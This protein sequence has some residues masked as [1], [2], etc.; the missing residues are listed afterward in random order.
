MRVMEKIRRAVPSAFAEIFGSDRPEFNWQRR[1]G[2]IAVTVPEL[3]A[4][5]LGRPKSAWLRKNPLIAGG[6]YFYRKDFWSYGGYQVN[7]LMSATQQL[8]AYATAGTF[9]IP[10]AT[11]INATA[12]IWHTN[13][14]TAGGQFQSPEV[15]NV[16]TVSFMTNP[17]MYIADQL[18]VLTNSYLDM[19]IA[20]Q[21]YA[22]SLAMRMPA[23]GGVFTASSA[24]SGNGNPQ[25]ANNYKTATMP[26]T[27]GNGIQTDT[28]G[29]V[30]EQLQKL[31]LNWSPQFSFPN[32][33][34]ATAA[35]T[36][37]NSGTAGGIGV[38]AWGVVCGQYARQ[39]S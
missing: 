16:L 28:M 32:G 17:A 15:L 30:V 34:N 3:D 38:D 9:I 12:S 36:T 26:G 20:N 21:S 10:G 6:L 35:Y 11:N 33:A 37:A 31:L 13:M 29:E 7:T 23:G 25:S 24:A 5:D 39:I 14:D 8:F 2:P 1:S 22:V 4:S 19:R 18:A 27:L